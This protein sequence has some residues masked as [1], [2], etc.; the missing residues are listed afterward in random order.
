MPRRR[1]PST[2]PGS[3]QHADPRL[4]RCRLLRT[5]RPHHRG[6]P[7]PGCRHLRSSCRR[8]AVTVLRP[9][10][11]AV[12]LHVLRAVLP[13]DGLR[14]VRLLHP[15]GLLQGP[16]RGGQGQPAANAGLDNLTDDER[17]A[18]GDGPTALDQLLARLADIP[19]PSGPVPC[20]PG[21]PAT[22]VLLPIADVRH[23]TD[24]LRTWNSKISGP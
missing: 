8:R 14:Q 20:Q 3:P 16:A 18:I 17:A 5:Q 7:R 10:P 24:S 9:R 21:I 22:P 11:R 13:P 6:S 4:P 12:F 2:T 19:T 23:G 15:E 1:P